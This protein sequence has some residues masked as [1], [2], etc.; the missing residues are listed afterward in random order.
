MQC[1]SRK[2]KKCLAI[3]QKGHVLQKAV[4][5]KSLSACDKYFSRKAFFELQLKQKNRVNINYFYQEYFLLAACQQ[6]EKNAR[7][8]PFKLSLADAV[9]MLLTALLHSPTVM[10]LSHL[11]NLLSQIELNVSFDSHTLDGDISLFH[12]AFLAMSSLY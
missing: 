8:R 3:I 12:V 9:F 7:H 5:K 1:A 11:I 2:Q 10:G 6:Q 4:L